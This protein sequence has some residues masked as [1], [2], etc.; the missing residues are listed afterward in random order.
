MLM[1]AVRRFLTNVGQPEIQCIS[2]QLL[3]IFLARVDFMLRFVLGFI[4][5]TALSS[6]TATCIKHVDAYLHDGQFGYQHL[7]DQASVTGQ[8]ASVAGRLLHH[9]AS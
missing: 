2:L 4:Y 1:C 6:N 5:G 9:V 7:I 8:Q 3:Q